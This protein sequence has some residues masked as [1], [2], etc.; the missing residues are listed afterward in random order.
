MH[1][2][3]VNENALVARSEVDT[4]REEHRRVAMRVEGYDVAVHLLRLGVQLCFSHE[5]A[6]E[7]QTVVAHPFGM[8]LHGKDRL[9]LLHALHG[10]NDAVG[11]H[12]RHLQ[13]RSGVVDGLVVERVD[14][15][16]TVFH[17]GLYHAAHLQLHLVCGL[18]AVSVLRVFQHPFERVDVLAHMS[19]K[20]CDQR[21]H[22]AADA[23]DRHAA[24]IGETCDEQLCLV[25]IAVDVV[26]LWRGLLVLPQ[27]V[28]VGPAAKDESVDGVER[29]YNDVNVVDGRNE[30]RHAASLHHLF[31]IFLSQRGVHALVVGRYANDGS[32][33]C[34]GKLAVYLFKSILKI[35]FT[36][37]KTSCLLHVIKQKSPSRA[38]LHTYIW[39]SS[40]DKL[41][42]A[43]PFF[44]AV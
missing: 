32:F 17:V 19:A 34:F 44:K 21:L 11:C 28:D 26:Q 6:E 39:L 25:A 30:H 5:P 4:L 38:A 40:E 8:P 42:T 43:F 23:E 10:L 20:G 36:H 37:R 35:E 22:A 29:V 41:Q 2:V 14:V 3:Q 9:L 7:G 12:R 1:L 27:G 13:V 18:R 31:I 33:L 16:R 24:V 15:E